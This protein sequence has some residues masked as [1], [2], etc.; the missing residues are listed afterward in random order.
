MFSNKRLFRFSSVWSKEN[1][2]IKANNFRQMEKSLSKFGKKTF[3]CPSSFCLTLH[4]YVRLPLPPLSAFSLTSLCLQGSSSSS[5]FS[6]VTSCFS[7]S[8]D[9][10]QRREAD[11]CK[12]IL[13]LFP[14]GSSS[15]KLVGSSIPALLHWIPTSKVF[16]FVA[17]YYGWM[18][19]SECFSN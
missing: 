17:L 12:V 3:V 2:W 7:F 4:V 9:N 13:I 16:L 5:S 10:K 6:V 1:K 14:P 8:L 15:D 11:I 19:I 18:W